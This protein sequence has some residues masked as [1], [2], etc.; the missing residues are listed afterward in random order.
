MGTAC[1]ENDTASLGFSRAYKSLPDTTRE[2]VLYGGDTP[3]SGQP[4]SRGNNRPYKEKKTLLGTP[5][6][7]SEFVCVTAPD[8]AAHVERTTD[9]HHPSPFSLEYLLLPPRSAPVAAP[10]RLTSAASMLTTATPLLS[11]ALHA[12]TTT[13]T[14]AVTN[15]ACDDG[16]VR[17]RWLIYHST[18]D[19]STPGT[20][21][22]RG[23]A[24]PPIT[25]RDDGPSANPHI[26]GSAT[27]RPTSAD[28]HPHHRS[29]PSHQQC[30][31]STTQQ[32]LVDR[33]HTISRSSTGAPLRRSLTYPR[34][35]PPDPS[36]HPP[37]G[38]PASQSAVKPTNWPIERAGGVPPGEHD[39]TTA[40]WQSHRSWCS[41]RRKCTDCKAHRRVACSGA[42]P[43]RIAQTA[44]SAPPT[45][46]STRPP[47][48]H[49]PTHPTTSPPTAGQTMDRQ[50]GSRNKQRRGE[51]V[52]VTRDQSCSAPPQG[53]DHRLSPAH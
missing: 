12:W 26:A 30:S 36:I 8:G 3:I 4:D 33:K 40:D 41:P 44:T 16:P 39:L 22:T 50:T 18:T 31:H 7:V 28:S 21:R 45:T 42:P 5:A 37:V 9:R 20:S 6:D 14:R 48:I 10:P 25:T 35:F 19:C 15:P 47:H 38:Q 23:N 46:H 29:P 24:E 13:Q 2:V 53:A 52:T 27:A 32:Q 49:A 11:I 51:G 43:A 17:A 1:H 34:L